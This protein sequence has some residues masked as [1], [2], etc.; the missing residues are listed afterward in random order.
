MSGRTQ[1]IAFMHPTAERLYAVAK[2]MR[3]IGTPGALAEALD[4]VHQTVTNWGRRGV[5][6]PGALKAQQ[7][8]GCDANWLLTG[9]GHILA[10]WPFSAELFDAVRKLKGDALLKAENTLRLHLDLATIPAL[11][12]LEL[13]DSISSEDLKRFQNAHNHALG[14]QKQKNH[15]A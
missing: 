8:F 13:S 6:I 1:T 14:E 5:S 9:R 3:G 10:G 2:A 11:E 4:E 15:A 7:V 12:P